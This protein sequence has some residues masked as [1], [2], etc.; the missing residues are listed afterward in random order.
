MHVDRAILVLEEW[1]PDLL[2]RSLICSDLKPVRG[3]R[4]GM[5]PCWGVQGTIAGLSRSCSMLDL[6]SLPVFC[7]SRVCII[8]MGHVV[9]LG[10][11]N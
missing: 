11:I 1:L 7:G 2:E 9:G 8:Y 5:S 3:V 6:D 10:P 4:L